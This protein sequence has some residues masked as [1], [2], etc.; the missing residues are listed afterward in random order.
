MIGDDKFSN[1]HMRLKHSATSNFK[2]QTRKY[3]KEAIEAT[4]VELELEI[5][6]EEN[7]AR[8]LFASSQV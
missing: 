1:Q 5:D 7:I 8:Q 6:N 2:S 3:H 4:L